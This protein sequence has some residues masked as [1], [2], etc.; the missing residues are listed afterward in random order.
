MSSSKSPQTVLVLGKVWPEPTSSAAGS[1]IIQILSEFQRQDFQIIF[2]SSAGKTPFSHDLNSIGIVEEEIELNNSSFDA[3]VAKLKPNIVLFD[4]F[5]TEEQFGWRVAEN[6]PA[7]LRILDTEDLHCLREGRRLAFKD[8]REFTTTDL[9]NNIAKR[10]IA[11]ILRCD[12]SLIISEVEMKLLRNHFRILAELLVYVPFIVDENSNK[13]WNSFDDREHF[14]SIG[15]FLH[16]PNWDA[17]LYLKQSIWPIIRSQMPKA[18]LHIYGAYPSQKVHQLHNPKEGFLIK[19]RV[20][21]AL[22]TIEKYRVL[23]APLRFGAGLKGK[24]LDAMITGTPSIT[25]SI[26]AEGMYGDLAWPGAIVDSPQQFGD[27]SIRL[28][29]KDELWEA[30]QSNIKPILM[31]RFDTEHAK[32]FLEIV[33]QLISTLDQHRSRNFVGQMLMHHSMASTKFMSK[34]IEEKNKIK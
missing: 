7:A 33:G 30:A 5:S 22:E 13:S 29:D 6:C 27:E 10:E 15:N 4:R 8:G 21:D 31:H 26:G 23:I 1:R 34:W 20:D 2:A 9:N 11:S 16:E 19:G 28:H 12:L 25:T 18:E 14:V 24:L 3:F 17:V 32:R